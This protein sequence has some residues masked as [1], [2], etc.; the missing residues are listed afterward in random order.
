LVDKEKGPWDAF[1]TDAFI[2]IV[3]TTVDG[4]IDG[5]AFIA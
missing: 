5:L 2:V 3:K 1:T 4:V